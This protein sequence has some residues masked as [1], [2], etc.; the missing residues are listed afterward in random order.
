[1]FIDFKKAF[2]RIWHAALWAT[3]KKYN[4]STNLIQVIKNLY[5]KT[6]SAVLFNGSIGDWFRTTVGVRQGCLLSPTLFNMFLERIMTDALE[7]HEGTVSIRGRTITNLRFA[8]DIDGLEGKEEEMANLVERLDKAST[9]YGT[10]ISAEKT[11]LMSNNTSGIN[12]EIKVNGQK[13]ETVT[14]FKYLGSIITDEGSKP[15]L[16]CRIA[17]ATAALTRLKP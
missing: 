13:L 4:I 7:D 2:D 14:S 15:E 16:L 10:E 11:K 9:A 5:N 17:Q 12:T 6:T 3:M 1:V 8:D